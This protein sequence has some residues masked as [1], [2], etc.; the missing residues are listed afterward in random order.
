MLRQRYL[1]QMTPESPQGQR[2]KEVSVNLTV[3]YRQLV[4]SYRIKYYCNLNTASKQVLRNDCQGIS[5]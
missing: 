4:V 3:T 2:G 1:L 5:D